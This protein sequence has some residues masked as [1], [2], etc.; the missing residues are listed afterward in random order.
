MYTN[1]A[2]A[3]AAESKA[4]ASQTFIIAMSFIFSY[5]PVSTVMNIKYVRYFIY[6]QFAAQ[7]EEALVDARSSLDFNPQWAK[8]RQSDTSKARYDQHRPTFGQRLSDLRSGAGCLTG[9][10]PHGVC[11]AAAGQ[12]RGGEGRLPAGS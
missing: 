12:A 2:A 9:L 6:F 3:Y 1:R 10:L 11:A 4:R 8:A 5:S 7:W